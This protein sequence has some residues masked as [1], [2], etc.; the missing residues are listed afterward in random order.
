MNE[1]R[2]S[3]PGV[4]EE[5]A[6]PNI[7]AGDAAA[8]HEGTAGEAA[9]AGDPFAPDAPDDAPVAEDDDGVDAAVV[10]D[11]VDDDVVVDEE[12]ARDE[13]EASA[14]EEAK[15]EAAARAAAIPDD[16]LDRIVEAL[17]FASSDALTP[18]K[19]AQAAGGLSPRRVRQS[20]DRLRAEYAGRLCS[21]DVME[22]AGGYRLYTRPEYQEHVARLEK[23]KAPEK[24]SAAS[25]ETLAI[26]AYRQPIIRADVDSIRGVQSGAILKSLM[27]RRLIRVVGRSDQPGRPLQYG[28]TKRFL[29]HFGLG[30]I[31]DL[32]RVEDLK[33]P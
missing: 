17:L 19:I 27:D 23:M 25:L 2:D 7:V 5:A 29:D 18:V 14:D 21:F 16:E 4:A 32:P 10:D 12:S 13:H 3:E 1:V 31:R 30:S 24:L 33:A 22:I 6:L 8:G 20:I 11:V 28:T 9:G 15:A 26:I